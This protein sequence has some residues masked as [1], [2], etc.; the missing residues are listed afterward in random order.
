M[1]DIFVLFN[2][3]EHGQFFLESMNKKH[4]NMK[5][6]IETEINGP[7]S[8]LDVKI[9]QENDKFVTSVFRKT[10]IQKSLLIN[11]FKNSLIIC[12]FKDYKFHIYRQNV[13]NC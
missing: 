7:L 2:K 10:Y 5:F 9:F 1:D 11:A 3:P 8:F 12:L 13:S 6:S 4:K